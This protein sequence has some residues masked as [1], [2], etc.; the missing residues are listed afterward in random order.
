M[1]RNLKRTPMET[2]E[3]LQ[4][5]HANNKL[6]EVSLAFREIDPHRTGMVTSP[7]MDD[8][9]RYLYPEEFKDKHMYEITKP[10]E[11]ISNKILIDYG[12]FRQWLVLELRNSTKG[13]D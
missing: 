7:E 5:L 1:E 12:K 11:V 6:K 2:Q 13:F 9:F 8:I 3:L 4:L 10:F